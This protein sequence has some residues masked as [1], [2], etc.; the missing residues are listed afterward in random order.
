MA[1]SGL[2][3]MQGTVRAQEL[4]QPVTSGSWIVERQNDQYGKS[5]RALWLL[6]LEWGWREFLRK[7]CIYLGLCKQHFVKCTVFQ[8]NTGVNRIL[9]VQQRH[10]CFHRH[11]TMKFLLCI[12]LLCRSSALH[13]KILFSFSTMTSTPSR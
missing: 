4:W 11:P 6:L 7:I 3:T 12:P 13:C 1:V 2:L 8:W 5:C 10:I 9:A